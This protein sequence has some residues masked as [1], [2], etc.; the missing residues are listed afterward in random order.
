MDIISNKYWAKDSSLSYVHV[1]F[2]EKKN[3]TKTNYL[4]F[5]L[6]QRKRYEDW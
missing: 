6:T 1:L 3:D 2:N 4:E 5:V